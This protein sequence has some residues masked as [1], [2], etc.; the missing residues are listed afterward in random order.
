MGE[1]HAGR[2]DMPYGLVGV[3]RIVTVIPAE[4]YVLPF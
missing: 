4:I 2:I 1:F 3:D